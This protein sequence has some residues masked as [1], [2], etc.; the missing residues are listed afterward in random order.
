M[1]KNTVGV[2]FRKLHLDT[3]VVRPLGVESL[4]DVRGG[5]PKKSKVDFCTDSWQDWCTSSAG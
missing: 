4:V 1:K 5:F 2:G 3:T